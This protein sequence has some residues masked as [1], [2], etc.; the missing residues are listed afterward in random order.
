MR[1]QVIYAFSL[2]PIRR[3]IFEIVGCFEQP[4]D[5]WGWRVVYEFHNPFFNIIVDVS[6]VESGLTSRVEI[7]LR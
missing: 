5:Q 1:Q 2:Q 7:N 3:E 6:V 4:T